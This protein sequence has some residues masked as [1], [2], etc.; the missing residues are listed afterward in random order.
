M[1]ARV[2]MVRTRSTQPREAGR[3]QAHFESRSGQC[4]VVDATLSLLRH[5]RLPLAHGEQVLIETPWWR[6]TKDTSPV[7]HGR[8][9]ASLKSPRGTTLGRD[10]VLGRN[11]PRRRPLLADRS[12]DGDANAFIEQDLRPRGVLV[13]GSDAE[14]SWHR[15]DD[16]VAQGGGSESGGSPFSSGKDGA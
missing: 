1:L 4:V 14:E 11:A 2:Q 12:R 15:E 5:V 10:G 6:S 3:S 16:A 8:Q 7:D 9:M 13:I